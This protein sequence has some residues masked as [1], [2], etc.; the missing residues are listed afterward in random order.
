MF[1]Y[2]SGITIQEIKLNIKDVVKVH[3]EESALS[4]GKRLF[5]TVLRVDKGKFSFSLAG[6]VR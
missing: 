5:W 1:Q 2:L 3:V 4:P 6:T